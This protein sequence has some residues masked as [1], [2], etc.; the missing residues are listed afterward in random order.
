[1]TEI[2]IKLPDDLADRLSRLAVERASTPQALLADAVEW[3][4]ADASEIEA[5]IARGEADF[6]AGRVVSHEE[7][8]EGLHRIISSSP[9][10]PEA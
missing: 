5:A 6:V 1:M 10:N 9:A 4:L 3:L 8:M 2:K 7:V